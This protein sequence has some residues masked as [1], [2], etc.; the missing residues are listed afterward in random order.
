MLVLNESDFGLLDLTAFSESTI[1]A[2]SPSIRYNLEDVVTAAT[3]RSSSAGSAVGASVAMGLGA[4]GLRLG[5]HGGRTATTTTRSTTAATTTAAAAMAT[6]GV[7]HVTETTTKTTTLAAA[8]AATVA[9]TRTTATT[10]TTVTAATTTTT[11]A[12]A[13][14]TTA[15][16][17]AIDDIYSG[18]N[19]D[20]SLSDELLAPFLDLT[21]ITSD[22]GYSEYDVLNGRGWKAAIVMIYVLVIAVGLVGNLLTVYS[23]PCLSFRWPYTHFK[24]KSCFDYQIYPDFSITHLKDI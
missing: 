21:N 18:P 23:S 24:E 17:P 9:T 19:D 13:A 11:T 7:N 12:A 16:I 3:T 10:S 14:I 22:L 20:V 2:T 1:V 8:V 6:I 4:L 5:G 15:E